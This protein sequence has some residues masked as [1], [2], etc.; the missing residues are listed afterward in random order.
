MNLL[1]YFELI[2]GI[3]DCSHGWNETAYLGCIVLPQEVGMWDFF[4]YFIQ[5]DKI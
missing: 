3:I 5:N 1:F 2:L 4:G